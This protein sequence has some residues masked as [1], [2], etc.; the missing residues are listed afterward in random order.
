M[1]TEKRIVVAC[2]MG[3]ALGALIALQL[4]RYFWWVGILA[5]GAIGY[6][7]YR[8][9]EVAQSVRLAWK[10]LPDVETLTTAVKTGIWNSALVVGAAIG[11]I[12]CAASMLTLMVGGVMALMVGQGSTVKWGEGPTEVARTL[13]ITG[14]CLGVG[15]IVI[16]LASIFLFICVLRSSNRKAACWGIIGCLLMNP[17]ILPI[18][19]FVVIAWAAI[20]CAGKAAMKLSVLSFKILRRT[21][22]MIHS[23][24]RLLCMTDALIGALTGFFFGNAL[25][26]GIVGAVCGL[27]NYKFVS[28]KWLKLAKA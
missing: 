16:C 20:P 11:V 8:F 19:V 6:I 21:F 12:C 9:K 26:G 17:L 23:E 28:V 14:T 5:G 25:I 7:C 18:T 15:A 22:I 3:A 13:G 4:N 10:S 1:N 27:L 24:M 2:F